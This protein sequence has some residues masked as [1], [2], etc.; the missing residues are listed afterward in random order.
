[1]N[2]VSARAAGVEVKMAVLGRTWT[3]TRQLLS[4]SAVPDGEQGI[5]SGPGHREDLTTNAQCG[6]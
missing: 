4:D 3:A 6:V 1:M 2:V 5:T